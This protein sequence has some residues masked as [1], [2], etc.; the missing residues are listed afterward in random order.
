MLRG[1]RSC[2]GWESEYPLG[3]GGGFGGLG[4]SSAKLGVLVLEITHEF[5][6]KLKRMKRSINLWAQANQCQANHT[7]L[8]VCYTCI[9]QLFIF[10]HFQLVTKVCNVEAFN[11]TFLGAQ[12]QTL[13][14]PSHQHRCCRLMRPSPRALGRQDSPNLFITNHA[15]HQ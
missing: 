12:K 9:Q 11:E 15:K 7:Q 13:P 2:W 8:F 6:V 10:I 1:Q 14:R 5:N 4:L 3:V